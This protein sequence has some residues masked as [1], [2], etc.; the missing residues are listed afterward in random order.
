MGVTIFR[1]EDP[2]EFG[3]FSRSFC[4]LFRIVAGETW[5]QDL[6]VPH[7]SPRHEIYTAVQCGHRV[8]CILVKQL[9]ASVASSHSSAIHTRPCPRVA[10]HLFMILT[11]IVPSDWPTPAYLLLVCWS[12]IKM[13][14]TSALHPAI[15][16]PNH[17]PKPPSHHFPT[18][19]GICWPR[20]DIGHLQ[21]TEVGICWGVCNNSPAECTC[22]ENG[23]CFRLLMHWTPTKCF[24]Q[25]LN[26]YNS[27]CTVLP[28]LCMLGCQRRLHTRVSWS[29]A[30]RELRRIDDYGDVVFNIK[31]I[32][33]VFS[34]I[35]SVN[36]VGPS[37]AL[38]CVP[39]EM[40]AWNLS[41]YLQKWCLGL[42]CLWK[43]PFVLKQ[44]KCECVSHKV[45]RICVNWQG[46]NWYVAQIFPIQHWHDVLGNWGN[47][48]ATL[49]VFQKAIFLQW[50]Q[51]WIQ[52]QN[53]PAGLW[54]HWKFYSVQIK[55]KNPW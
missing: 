6:W 22:R 25:D 29:D 8:L 45:N 34:F 30:G 28:E 31:G 21:A 10:T 26:E 18:M 32:I 49:R 54:A 19:L 17:Y 20:H 4:T 55:P 24:P 13:T 51:L 46:S 3:T 37:F 15:L 11:P 52:L 27:E 9:C 40:Q 47:W 43:S 53:I 44:N 35:L 16:A 14:A 39:H 48:T 7:I 23:Y 12:R 1:N 33:F 5:C 36:W 41:G 50:F 42:F 38:C 2:A